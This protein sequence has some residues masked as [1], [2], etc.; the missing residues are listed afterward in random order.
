MTR[1][2]PAAVHEPR[3]A[4]FASLS[5]YAANA[6]G[7]YDVASVRHRIAQGRR[8]EE[9]PWVYR[10]ACVGAAGGVRSARSV[11]SEP[12]AGGFL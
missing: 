2:L 7:R 1:P 3:P 11:L 9:T 10:R 6:G 4:W 8:Q 5:A 12:G